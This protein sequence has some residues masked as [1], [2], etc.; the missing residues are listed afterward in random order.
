[1]TDL[2]DTPTQA[3]VADRQTRS[4]TRGIVYPTSD[5]KPMAETDKHRDLATYAI[6]ALKLHFADRPDVYIAG[7]N[8][9]YYQEGSPKICVSPDLY[10]VFGVPMRQRDCYMAWNEGGKLPDVVLEFTSRKTRREDTHRKRPQYE[11]ELRV[12]EYFLFDPTGDYLSPRLQ[13]YRLDGARYVPLEVV[14]GRLYSQR[15]QLDLVQQGEWLRLFDPA[16]GEWLLTYQ[17]QAHR[18]EQEAL[19]AEQEA[20]ARV[21]AEAETARLREELA[22]LRRQMERGAEPS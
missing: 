19:R 14:D 16:R 11:Q 1:M 3:E 17:E 22:A 4:R 21:A 9:L 5:G 7:N 13:G 15:L 8:F 18:A 6:E 2:A 20:S 10:V 12:P